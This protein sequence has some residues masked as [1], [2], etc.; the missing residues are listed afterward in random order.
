MFCD[1][2]KILTTKLGIGS[3]NIARYANCDQSHISRMLSGARVPKSGGIAAWT[4]VNGLY[5][6]VD[7]NGKTDLLC[8]LI[9]CSDRGSAEIVKTQIMSWLYEREKSAIK[10]TVPPQ[11]KKPYRAFG[12]KLGAVMELTGLS[13]IRL[14]KTLNIDPSYISRFRNGFR[15]PKSNSKMMADI[16]LSLLERV[17][18][19]GK[20]PALAKLIG[21]L[22][23]ELNDREKAF[24]SL[25]LWFFNSDNKDSTPF[26]QIIID[27]IGSFPSDL[28]RPLLSFEEAA[29][30]TSLKDSSQIYYGT[31]GLRRAVLRFLGNV[32]ERGEK[33][34]FLYSDQNMDWMV[35][36]PLFLAKWTS[37]MVRCVSDEIKINIIHNINRDLSEM[38]DAIKSWIPLYP[39]GM[40]RSYYHK[41]PNRSKFSTTLFLCPG[42]ACISG[43]NAAGSENSSGMY[44]YDTEKQVLKAH[45]ATYR[46]L[47]AGSGEL[48]HTYKTANAEFFDGTDNFGLS[49]LGN[50]LSLAT[51]PEKTLISVLE[52]IAVD[53]NAKARILEERKHFFS[54]FRHKAESG[55]MHEYIPIPNDEELFNKQI[56]IDI[57]GVAATYTPTEYTEHIQNVISLS[58]AYPNY[59]FFVIPEVPFENIKLLIT[60]RFAAAVRLKPPYLTIRFEHPDLC[61]AFVTYAEHIREQYQQ[62]R[63][64]TKRLLERFL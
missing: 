28:K 9:S 15:S 45:E 55:F 46:E 8:D 58:D 35:S 60:D 30:T 7:D 44:R 31:D 12:E 41:T 52:R 5:L 33:E 38:A 37:L 11:E 51:M 4:L 16:C 64:S 24:D 56:P 29:D 21:V 47:L 13:N 36:D 3:A 1:R 42:Y 20:Q 49:V 14:G 63:I 61:R 59:R 54:V 40:I 57:P 53:E 39:S 23:D 62:D 18:D 34:L 2:V 22:A 17:Y 43:C 10:S 26:V 27:Q 6:C 32:I 50:T 25:Y 19:Q 48:I